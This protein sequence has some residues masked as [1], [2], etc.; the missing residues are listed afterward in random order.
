M[1][2]RQRRLF[3]PEIF[4]ANVSLRITLGDQ[5]SGLIVVITD[6]DRQTVIACNLL[7]YPA[8]QRIHP[9]TSRTGRALQPDETTT[10]IILPVILS[11]ARTI[12]CCIIGVSLF[13]PARYPE[14]AVAVRIDRMDA[15]LAAHGLPDAVA[16]LVVGVIERRAVAPLR[17]A[18]ADEAIQRIIGI[19]TVLSRRGFLPLTDETTHTIVMYPPEGTAQ[20]IGVDPA[21]QILAARVSLTGAVGPAL[22]RAEGMVGDRTGENPGLTSVRGNIGQ[23]DLGDLTGCLAGNRDFADDMTE[24]ASARQFFG[25]VFRTNVETKTR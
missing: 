18:D 13:R 15:S 12:T 4:A 25:T 6:L 21:I 8:A 11:V 1:H 17:Q 23:C 14:Q 10:G 5:A 3:Q 22:D 16:G 2:D 20:R 7:A 24:L 19:L 9:V